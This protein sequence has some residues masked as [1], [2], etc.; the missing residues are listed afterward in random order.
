MHMGIQIAVKILLDTYPETRL[1]DHRGILI[2]WGTAMLPSTG[3]H[4][5][6]KS[7]T[8]L[9][10]LVISCLLLLFNG[11]HPN[12]CEMEELFSYRDG[13]I[14][15]VMTCVYLCWKQS[16]PETSHLPSSTTKPLSRVGDGES[17]KMLFE[18]RHRKRCPS[19]LVGSQPLCSAIQEFFGKAGRVGSLLS[20]M[21]QMVINCLLCLR[22]CSGCYKCST[23]QDEWVLALPGFTC[24]CR[25]RD[26]QT[27]KKGR[28][29]Q[30]NFRHR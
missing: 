19:S 3:G 18:N 10:T 13:S 21:Q 25:E 6:S 24:S 17:E 1:L 23:E 26:R 4:K 7:S 27:I 9:P 2:F 30:D 12:G 20:F 16:K 11:S 29:K 8:P 28:R 15:F 5:G 22:H 14:I